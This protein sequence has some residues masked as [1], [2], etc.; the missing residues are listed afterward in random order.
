MRQI[1]VLATLLVVSHLSVGGLV[2]IH[3]FPGQYAGFVQEDDLQVPFTD[4]V[5]LLD[6]GCHFRECVR[7]LCLE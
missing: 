7:T 2:E 3:D 4:N 1:F 6:L 5:N